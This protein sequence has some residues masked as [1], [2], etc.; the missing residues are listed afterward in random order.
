MH[1]SGVLILLF[2]AVS[3]NL[4]AQKSTATFGHLTIN[5]GLSQNSIN[6]IHQ[7]RHGFMWFGTHDGLNRYDGYQFLHYRSERNNI[8]SLSNNYI[9]DIHEDAEGVLWIATF[10]GGLNSLNPTTGEVIRHTMNS[11]ETPAIPDSRL[12][13]I[14]EFP[15]GILWIGSNEGLIRYDKSPGQARLFLASI[16]EDHIYKDNYVGIVSAPVAGGFDTEHLWLQCDSGLARFNTKT[17]TAEYF[18]RSPFSN[19]YELGSVNDIVQ[20]KEGLLMVCTS[21]LMEVNLMQKTDRL[22]LSA[23]S[24]GSG[25]AIA[26]MHKLL[27]LGKSRYAIGTNVGLVTY[28]SKTNAIALFQNDDFDDKSLTHNNILSLFKSN[29]GIL[30][31]GTRNGLNTLETTGT[32]LLHLRNLPGSK[33]LS[34]K[35]VS[36]F[37]RHNDSL[38]WIGTTDGLNLYNEN[39]NTFR[40]FKKDNN[41]PGGLSSDYILYLF[42][43]RDGDKWVGTR[44]GGFYKIIDHGKRGMAFLQIQPAN[45]TTTGNTSH[46]ITDGKDGILWIGTG[47]KGLW[48]Y[49]KSSNVVLKKYTTAKNGSGLSHPYVFTILE[50]S[51]QNLWLGTPSGGL[52]LFNPKTEQFLY[53]QHDPDNEHSI[54]NDII[55]SLY[56]DQEHTLWIGTNDGLARLIPPLGKDIFNTLKKAKITGNDSLFRNY[57]QQE[58]FANSVA[59]GILEDRQH[60]LWISSNRGISTFDKNLEKVIKTLDAGDGLQSNE[61]NQNAYYQ[62]RDGF[63]CFG[64]VNGANIFHPDSLKINTFV[65]PVVLTGLSIFNEPLEVGNTAPQGKLQLDKA[66]HLL[67]QVNFSWKDKMITFDFASL[68]FIHPEKNRYKYMLEGFNT[69]WVDAGTRHTATYTH[70]SPGTYTFKVIACNN[71]GVWNKNGININVNISTPPW[72]RWYAYLAY[73]L[74]IL[75]IIYGLIQYYINRARRELNLQARIEKA[76]SQERAEFRKQSASDFHDEAGNKITKITLLTEMARNNLNDTGKTGDYLS[77]IQKNLAELSSGMRDFL[78]VMDARHDTLF[79]TI[80]RIKDF[81]DSLLTDMGIHFSVHGLNA[82]FHN[83]LLPMNTRRN[84]LQIFKEAINNCAKHASPRAVSLQV[85]VVDNVIEIRLIDDG[86][87]FD[88]SNEELKHHYGMNI[89]MERAEKIGAKL[90]IKSQKSKGTSILLKINMPHSGNSFKVKP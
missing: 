77:K 36:S 24:I 51:F 3:G 28:N 73:I 74:T 62:D 22:V 58:G 60:H 67:D 41:Y 57:G 33:G 81:G 79:E 13:S 90:E 35:N 9:Y 85:K 16:N 19:T 80:T 46:F 26:V 68:S 55:L 84:I 5:D 14:T 71:S 61:F 40:I 1:K 54:S 56:E 31:A 48:K 82:W 49:D 59:Y 37:M 11:G 42:Q 6:C 70:L 88:T 32:G 53:F 69:D 29:D 30:W 39:S 83:I 23:S 76:R 86:V 78:W 17:L 7:D 43:D 20:T 63:F 34:S 8:N 4:P 66:V 15:E 25:E 45:D 38:M 27:V 21:G 18:Q 72:N 89:M 87:G 64:G 47:G 65:P 10:G 52:N 12:F 50:D 44:R 2:L 75:A